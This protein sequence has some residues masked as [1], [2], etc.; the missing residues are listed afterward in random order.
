MLSR[1]HPFLKT[2]RLLVAC[3]VWV[4]CQG[5]ATLPH[6]SDPVA[7]VVTVAAATHASADQAAEVTAARS[8]TRPDRRYDEHPTAR[9]A[10]APPA[11]RPAIAPARDARDTAPPDPLYLQNC[12]LLC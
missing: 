1:G 7:L 8:A 11:R 3:L 10:A 2:L 6:M 12:A 5:H 4:F 9:E